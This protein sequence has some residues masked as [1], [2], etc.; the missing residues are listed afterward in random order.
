MPGDYDVDVEGVERVRKRM[1]QGFGGEIED[2]LDPV[3]AHEGAQRGPIRGVQAMKREFRKAAARIL[4][5]FLAAQKQVVHHANAC[6]LFPH[7]GIDQ[8]A[9]DETGASGDQDLFP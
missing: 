1:A 4:Q 7:Q 9:A 3:A 6:G 2:H 8:M 5:V